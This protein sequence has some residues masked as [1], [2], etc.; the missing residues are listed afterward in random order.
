MHKTTYMSS[1]S[2]APCEVFASSPL[3]LS[4]RVGVSGAHPRHPL[5]AG[6]PQAP[7]ENEV[8]RTSPPPRVSVDGGVLEI[9]PHDPATGCPAGLGEVAW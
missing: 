3:F 9:G 8:A 5:Y 7:G 6:C 1:P 2:Q 4:C